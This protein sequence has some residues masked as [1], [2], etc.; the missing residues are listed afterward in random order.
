MNNYFPAL[1]IITLLGLVGITLAGCTASSP[2]VTY[3][4]LLGMDAPKVVAQ[5][6][7]RLVLSVGPV[8]IPDILKKSQIATGGTDGRYQLSEYHRWAGDVDRELARALAEQLAGRLGTEQIIVFPGDQ[9]LEPNLQILL[10]VLAM[11]GELGRDANLTVRWT[12]IDSKGK[13]APIIRRSQLHQQPS[14]SGYDAWVTAQQHNINRLS[15]EI[16]ALIKQQR[17]L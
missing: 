12:L 16:A 4:S 15:E 9:H 2:Q 8:T 13:R 17:P 1:R 3:Y 7:D 6:Q 11:D 10:D 5:Q 14:G